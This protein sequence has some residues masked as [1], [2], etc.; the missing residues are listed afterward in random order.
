MADRQHNL[1]AQVLATGAPEAVALREG[2]RAWTYAQLADTVARMSAATTWLGVSP[3]E[4]V[5]ILMRDRLEA[6]APILGVIH[7]GA[8][9][10]PLSELARPDDLR[11]Y[12]A[13]ADAVAAFVDG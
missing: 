7:A 3:G 10:V 13:H 12:L 4:R 2:D 8:V 1:A 6:A 5:V 9:A 11:V